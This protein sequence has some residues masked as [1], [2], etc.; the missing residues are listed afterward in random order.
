MSD[1]NKQLL[2]VER[3]QYAL[4][5]ISTSDETGKKKYIFEGIFAVLNEMNRNRRIYTA[6]Q[7]IPQIT[8]IMTLQK[9]LI[10]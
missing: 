3:S 6:D 8:M 10:L 7:Y 4:S 9:F 1:K 5:N 2:I